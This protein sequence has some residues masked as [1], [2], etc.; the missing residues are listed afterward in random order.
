[1]KQK[2]DSLS[3]KEQAWVAAQLEKAA[4]FVETFS[5]ADAGQP[6]TLAALDRAF[7][8]WIAS[9]PTDVAIINAVINCVGA[10]FGR[11]LVEGIG[12]GW[13]IATDKHGSDL[14]IYGLPDKGDVLIYPANFV[15]KRWEK[16]EIDF[17]ESSYQ[18]IAAQVQNLRLRSSKP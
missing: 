4:Y 16:R 15:A 9:K 11:F 13:V 5:S 7:A 12:L 2:I 17:L 3:Q 6:L 10:A 8:A 1:M 18:Q 14:A